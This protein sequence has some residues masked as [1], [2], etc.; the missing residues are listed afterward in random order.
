MLLYLKKIQV[1]KIV[2]LENT[3]FQ[4]KNIFA[5][6]LVLIFS[7]FDANAQQKIGLEFYSFREHF[8]TNVPETMAMASR[9]GFTDVELSGTYNYPKE[10]FRELLLSNN[11]K[12]IS[13]SA[14]FNQLEKNPEEVVEEARS[15]GAKYVVCMWIPHEGDDFTIEDTEHAIKVFN[16]A[17]RLMAKS[18]IMLCYHSHGFEFRKQGNGYLFDVMA[19]KLNPAWVNFE[20]DVFWMKHAGQNPVA[21]LKKYPGRFPL[22]HLKDRKIGTKGNVNGRADVESN[23]TLGTGDVGIEKIMCASEKY[24]VKHYFIEDESSRSL[25][26]VPAGLHLLSNLIGCEQ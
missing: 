21:L 5:L 20:M 2:D 11:L 8:K 13:M 22:M 25:T 24:G 17:G 16:E 4:M 14:D 18:G 9:M 10:A 23:V 1:Y 19:R 3:F 7:F 26:Q 12:V 6:L 15:F